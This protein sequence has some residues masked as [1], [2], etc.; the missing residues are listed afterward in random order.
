MFTVLIKGT[1]YLDVTPICCTGGYRGLE[2]TPPLQLPS[3]QL[4]TDTDAGRAG[5]QHKDDVF[6][7]LCF[8]LHLLKGKA[9]DVLYFCCCHQTPL[10]D[11]ERSVLVHL[12]IISTPSVAQTLVPTEGNK[13]Y[14]KKNYIYYTFIYLKRL[15]FLK[16]LV[17]A[18]FFSK[19]QVLSTHIFYY[20]NCVLGD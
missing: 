20:A 12:S 10:K 8:T 5:H 3:L 13:V 7:Q 14:V 17:T 1:P 19:Y 9:G 11:Q 15:H 4:R 16:Q 2:Q 6:S 18:V